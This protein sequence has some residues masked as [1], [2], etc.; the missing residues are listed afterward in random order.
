MSGQRGWMRGC[1]TGAALALCA[2][3]GAHRDGAEPYPRA[4]ETCRAAES[5]PECEQRLEAYLARLDNLVGGLARGGRADGVRADSAVEAE[6]YEPEPASAPASP[7]SAPDELAPQ[8]GP[9]V[10]VQSAPQ[11]DI[12]DALT[13]GRSEDGPDCPSARDLR[14][15]ICELAEAI[16]ALAARSDAAPETTASCETAR[17]SCKDARERVAVT[18]PD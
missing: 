11:A 4:P 12:A 6:A 3:G 17:T 2:C 13:S 18:C 15:R 14:D 10:E 5:V 8:P 1:A 16:C 9:P 7:T